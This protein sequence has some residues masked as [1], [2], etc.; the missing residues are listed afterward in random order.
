M[1][2]PLEVPTPPRN[3][4]RGTSS[5]RIRDIPRQCSADKCGCMSQLI[6]SDRCSFSCLP[7]VANEGRSTPQYRKAAHLGSVH[8]ASQDGGPRQDE[9]LRAAVTPAQAEWPLQGMV[10]RTKHWP[11]TRRLSRLQLRPDASSTCSL[12]RQPTWCPNLSSARPMA[13]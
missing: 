12:T 9:K 3:L 6:T 8:L 7:T 13:H 10:S 2:P 1:R 5:R 11:V 4:W